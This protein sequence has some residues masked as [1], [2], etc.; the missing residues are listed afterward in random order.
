[1]RVADRDHQLPDPQPLCVA[2]LGGDEP[3]GGDP[4]Q[5]E[6]GERIGADDGELEVAAIGEGRAARR[7]GAGDDVR[8]GEHEAV[9]GDHD[10]AAASVEDTSAAD[11]PSH[12]EAGDRRRHAGGDRDHGPRVGVERLLAA[13]RIPGRARLRPAA[14]S[15][16][17]EHDV[18]H[19]DHAS[20]GGRLWAGAARPARRDRASVVT[21][22]RAVG[23]VRATTTSGPAPDPAPTPT[24]KPKP[25]PR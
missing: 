3:V 24:P 2:E 22:S 1:M 4:Q 8:R 14:R 16:V 25:K 11:A 21:A 20:C 19:R 13:V 23:S 6:V 15:S 7:V 18:C 10:A 17:D 12:A 5:R 9:G